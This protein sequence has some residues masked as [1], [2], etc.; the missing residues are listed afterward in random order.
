MN[1]KETGKYNRKEN[2]KNPG[3]KFSRAV[4]RL[5]FLSAVMR[6]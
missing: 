1:R 5:K 2:L 6:P 4:K 3:L